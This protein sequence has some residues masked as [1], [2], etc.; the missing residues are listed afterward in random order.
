MR[1]TCIFESG[2]HQELLAKKA[3][4]HDS[5]ITSSNKN[6]WR[7]CLGSYSRTFICFLMELS[8]RVCVGRVCERRAK[9]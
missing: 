8:Y 3:H 7:G 4:Y 2:T 5:P 1:L 6:G 9:A